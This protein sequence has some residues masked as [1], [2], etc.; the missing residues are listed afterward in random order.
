MSAQ[1]C[2]TD[3]R[4]QKRSASQENHNRQR[5]CLRYSSPKSLI[6]TAQ[7]SMSHER[8]L[9][10]AKALARDWDWPG[11]GQ[12]CPERQRT[13]HGISR[14]VYGTRTKVHASSFP[15]PGQNSKMRGQ[16]AYIEYIAGARSLLAPADKIRHQHRWRA[17]L[18]SQT[19]M[20]EQVA[21]GVYVSVVGTKS[22]HRP[23][24]RSELG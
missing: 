7:L 14:A 6:I 4:T 23:G 5:L 22:L 3:G 12:H 9:M 20:M 8:K 15:L 19:W 10:A 17:G 18:L 13:F 1:Q 16:E 11:M 21:Q 2:D 24:S